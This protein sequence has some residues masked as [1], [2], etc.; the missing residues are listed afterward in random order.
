MLQSQQLHG[1]HGG[2]IRMKVCTMTSMLWQLVR[3]HAR[4]LTRFDDL[5]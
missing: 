5:L 3:L 1:A 4:T 2:Y